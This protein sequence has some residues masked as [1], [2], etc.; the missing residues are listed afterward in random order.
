VVKARTAFF[1]RQGLTADTHYIAST[2]IEGRTAGY[3]SFVTMDALAVAGLKEAQIQFLHAPL[4]LNRTSEY[5][6]TFERGAA[7][8]FGDR[9]HI[10]ISGTASINHQGDVVH[11]GDILLQTQ[12]TLRN[13]EALLK[14]AN[15]SLHDIKQAIVYLRDTADYTVVEQFLRKETPLN[16][17]IVIAPVCRPAWL[18]EIECIAVTADGNPCFPNL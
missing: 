15:A 6:V 4:F 17:L 5:G 13:I 1:D 2:G 11:P 7:I 18:I 3:S 12:R 8:T 9:R 14:E 10:Y 16:Y